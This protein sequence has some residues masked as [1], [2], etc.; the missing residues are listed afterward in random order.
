MASTIKVDLVADVRRMRQGMDQAN[1]QLKG[2]AGAADKAGKVA[3]NIAGGVIAYAGVSKLKDVL[4]E[5]IE[6]ARESQKVNAATAATI[7]ATGRAA[8]VTA[9]QVGRLATAI[10]NKTGIDDEAIQ[11]GSNLLLTFKNVRN[12][13]G[14]G[15]KVF[16]EATKAAVDLSA[17]GFGSIEGASKMLGKALNDPVKGI[18]AMSRAGVTFTDQQ[19][20]QIKTLTESGR[21]LEAQKMILSEVKSQVGGVA[22][23][24]ATS[25]EKFATWVANLKEDLGTRLLPILDRFYE[26]A[27]VSLPA[28]FAAARE[29]ISPVVSAITGFVARIRSGQSEAAGPLSQVRATLTSVF[30]SIKSVISSTTIILTTLWDAFGG[31]IL[32]TIQTVLPL[33]IENLKA[34]FAVIA[35]I[36]KTVAALLRGDWRGAWNGIKSIVK[37]ALTI[38]V[39]AIKG[40]LALAKGAFGLAKTALTA[41]WR[42]AWTGIK[43][44]TT[45]GFGAV[46][47]FMKT[48]PEK[49]K[50]LFRSAGTWLKDAGKDIINGLLDGAGSILS[51]IG[52]FFL[53]KIPRWIRTPFKKALGIASPSKEFKRYGV[54]LIE[55]LIDG[56]DGTRAALRESLRS[57]AGTVAATRLALPDVT[58]PNL[59]RGFDSR[60]LI[61]ATPPG[62]RGDTIVN[63]TLNAPLLTDIHDAGRHLAGALNAYVA[64]GGKVRTS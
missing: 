29:A 38:I 50:G 58:A 7:K 1:A 37:N 22:E 61:T 59:P 49:V 34:G 28:A 31:T 10:S 40:S 11:T 32:N 2:F 13:A 45:A 52:E 14:K 60:S 4:G 56:L 27:M 57:V 36:F 53:N 6:E 47:A 3:R 51:K 19:K 64:I 24:S 25:G 18:T 46:V 35:G 12:E 41:L 15:N 23:A 17:A 26:W 33:A 9:G 55:G 20:E 42:A 54:N 48:I 8:N 63:L 16:N 30:E 21:T 39:N 43:A 44:A 62:A 5:S